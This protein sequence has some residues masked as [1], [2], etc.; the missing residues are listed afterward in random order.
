[1]HFLDSNGLFTGV[2]P[3]A[4][5]KQPPASNSP[6]TV[7]FRTGNSVLCV[8]VSCEKVVPKAEKAGGNLPKLGILNH[9]KKLKFITDEEVVKLWTQNS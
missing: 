8:R 2:Y 6:D 9:L 4:Q 5:Q 1:M 7:G 3:K